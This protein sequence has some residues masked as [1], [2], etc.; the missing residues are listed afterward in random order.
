VASIPLRRAVT[1]RIL[2]LTAAILLIAVG[3][4]VLAGRAA[5]RR[6]TTAHYRPH[7][8]Q[9]MTFDVSPQG[10]RLVFNA[11]GEGGR[12]LYLLD[13]K[14]FRV[15]CVARTPEYEVDPSFSPNGRSVVYAAGREGDRADHLFVR[16]LETNAARQITTGDANDCTPAFS[17]DGSL[18]VFTRDRDYQWGG[19]AAN[20]SG[21]G[22]LCFIR[23]DGSGFRYLS[24]QDIIAVDPHFSPD[25]KTILFWGAGGPFTVPVDGTQPPR[26]AAAGGRQAVWSKDGKRILFARGEY[27]TN[28]KIYSSRP[29]GSG[30]I[31]VA[32]APEGCFHPVVT[33]DGKQVFYLVESWPDGP[34]G[35]PKHSLWRAGMDGKNPTRLAD[36]RLFDDPL[37][38]HP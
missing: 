19:L 21:G 28:S 33:P 24:R 8:H 25:N 32:E 6:L 20:W 16:S 36:T 13:L 7:G 35:V 1:L 4:A 38:W 17:P 10:D 15:T 23:P 29:E 3:L 27:S 5:Y 9:D 11:A 34:G 31:Q 26:L 2:L 18:I 22:R 30:V 37:H 14:T 12:D